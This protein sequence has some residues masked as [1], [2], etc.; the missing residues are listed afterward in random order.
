MTI[1]FCLQATA[2][3][4]Q[5]AGMKTKE[6][7][8]HHRC[9]D[10]T[11]VV[12]SVFNSAETY[13]TLA[14]NFNRFGMYFESKK[15][16]LP[17]VFVLIRTSGVVSSRNSGTGFGGDVGFADQDRKLFS[18]DP[19]REL[20]MVIAAEVKRCVSLSKTDGGGYGIAV[21]YIDPAV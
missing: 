14:K 6:R 3:I 4:F 12:N 20:R 2:T 18:P 15:A 19:F 1:G 10:E 7:R 8:R 21:A 9:S 17:G 16:F 13:K 11:E 5:E